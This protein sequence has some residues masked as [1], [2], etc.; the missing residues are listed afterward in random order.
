MDGRYGRALAIADR[1]IDYDW[2]HTGKFCF[3]VF[4]GGA[5][6]D[7]GVF[8]SSGPRPVPNVWTFVAG[9][10]DDPN[11]RAIIF[12]E[13]KSLNGGAGGLVENRTIG[14]G[15]FPCH[16]SVRVGRHPSGP[17]VIEQGIVEPFDGEIDNVFIFGALLNA[18]ALELIRRHGAAAVLALARGEDL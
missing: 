2:Q 1:E 3:A 11:H 18:R 14:T 7:R 4:L 13:D 5:G 16:V 12:V 9:V 10:Y 8:S 6:V 17:G 15:F